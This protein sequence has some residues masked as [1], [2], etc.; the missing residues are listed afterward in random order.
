MLMKK[1][2]YLLFLLSMAVM[3]G[4]AQTAKSGY[5][6]DGTLYSYQLNPAMDAERGF[7]SLLAGNM[8][9]GTSG[10]VGISNFLYPYGDDKLTTFMSGTVAADKFLGRLPKAIRLGT[11]VNGT[12]LAAGFRMFGGYTTF[13]VTVHSSLSVSLP[14]DSLSLPRRVSLRMHIVLEAWVLIR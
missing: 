12:L 3:S 7:F 1:L 10:N 8:S 14:R 5:F 13:G 11:D 9:M 4:M 6:L 2:K